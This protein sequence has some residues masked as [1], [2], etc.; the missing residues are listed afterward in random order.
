MSLRQEYNFVATQCSQK[1]HCGFAWYSLDAPGFWSLLSSVL[2]PDT[3]APN[4]FS[5]SVSHAWLMLFVFFRCKVKEPAGF[6]DGAGGGRGCWERV[7]FV[8]CNLVSSHSQLSRSAMPGAP[9][10]FIVILTALLSWELHVAKC[11]LPQHFGYM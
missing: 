10:A 1:P 3:G 5:A 9:G 6:S 8:H 4:P 11:L 7:R 2:E